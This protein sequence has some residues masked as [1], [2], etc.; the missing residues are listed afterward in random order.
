ML[1]TSR[2]LGRRAFGWRPP[3]HTSLAHIAS[4]QSPPRGRPHLRGGR[5]VALAVSLALVAG[6][7]LAARPQAAV[8]RKAPVVAYRGLGAW[9]DMFDTFSWNDPA[10]AVATLAAHHVRTLYVETSNYSWA[11]ALNKPSQLAAFIELCHAQRPRIRVVAWYLPGLKQPT[12]DFKRSMAAINY[13]TPNG[14]HFNSFALDIEASI[15]KPVSTRNLRLLRLS[16]KIRQAVGVHYPLGAIIPSPAGMVLHNTYW[17]NFPYKALASVYD[18]MVPMGYYTYHGDG[19]THAYNETCDNVRIIRE[20]T[21]RS[22]I[23]IHVIAGVGNNSSASETQAYVRALRVNGCIG[24]SMYDLSTT[25][26]GGWRALANVRY[27]PVQKP[28][29][30][31]DLGYTAPLGNCKRD[32]THPQEVFYQTGGASTDM[33]LSFRLFDVQM[34]E[35]RLVVNWKSLGALPAG[36]RGKWSGTRTVSIPASMLRASGHNVIGFVARGKRPPW[37]RWAVRNV[38]LVK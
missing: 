32:R 5:L 27:N 13:R 35:V 7:G 18:V 9:V 21:G 14:Q 16:T 12:R 17:P 15:V 10:A 37:H 31:V 24:G 20:Q 1:R 36:P 38:Q 28:A 22:T 4:A 19:Y 34:D 33:V 11:T 25:D 30:P 8:A 3:A 29:L 6:A 23:P 26:D 2:R